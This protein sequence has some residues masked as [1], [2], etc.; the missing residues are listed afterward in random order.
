MNGYLQQLATHFA[1]IDG[2]NFYTYV[3]PNRRAGLFFRKY[4]GQALHKPVLAPEIMTINDCFHSLSD[5][6]IAD[7]LELIARLYRIYV[8]VCSEKNNAESFE[9]FLHWGQLMI[10]DFSEIDNHLVCNVKDLFTTIRDYQQLNHPADYLTKTQVEAIQQFWGD[11]LNQKKENKPTQQFL[12]IWDMLYPCYTQLQA[13]LINDGLAYEGLL[14]RKV[15]ESW[16]SISEEKFQLNT[17]DNKKKH[18]VFIGFN[19]LTAS[20]EKLLLLLQEKGIADFYFDYESPFLHD[21]QNRASLFHTHNAKLFHSQQSIQTFQSFSIPETTLIS[22][23][24]DIGETHQVYRILNQINPQPEDWTR[25]AIV[26]PDENILLP[27]LHAIPEQ[28]EKV[29]VTMG[30]PLQ[31]TK[32]FAPIRQAVTHPQDSTPEEAI[33]RLRHIWENSLNDNNS[34]IIYRLQTILNR[35]EDVLI[36]PKNKKQPIHISTDAF[37]QILYLLASKSS[38]SYIGE[39]LNGL[40]IMGVL[41]TRALDFDNLIITGFNDE[42]YPGK[43]NG[44]SFIPYTLRKGFGLPT[45]ERQDAI[46]A[47]NFYRMFSY[48][49]HVWLITNSQADDQHTGEVSRYVNQLKYQY[50]I[51]I[52]EQTIVLEN[53]QSTIKTTT[54]PPTPESLSPTQPLHTLSPS[55]LVAFLYCKRKYY[56]LYV[57]GLKEDPTNELTDADLGTAVHGVLEEL[58]QPYINQDVT[59]QIIQ[60]ILNRLPA[61][62]G[63]FKALNPIRNDAIMYAVA[64]QLITNQLLMDFHHP[65]HY[66]TSERI[67]KGSIRVLGKDIPLKGKIDRIDRQNNIL[68][69]IDYKT[70]NVTL[71]Y[72]T[73][74]EV[75]QTN[76]YTKVL[77]TLTY[78]YLAYQSGIIDTSLIIQPHLFSLRRFG[79]D[80]NTETLV[81]PSKNENN[82][83]S[84]NEIA[85]QVEQQLTNLLEKILTTSDYERTTEY[86]ACESCAFVSICR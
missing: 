83:F 68:R 80:T 21:P 2:A 78:C 27:L 67:V 25:T 48:A 20:E 36:K 74:D 14:H 42:L 72:S 1:N 53:T 18:F 17:L 29:N 70:G 62:W 58:Y 41:E 44:N 24:S 43:S 15:I 31:A 75:F 64:Q 23:P 60:Q 61:N 56:Y 9:Y 73:I 84:F 10:S 81:Q 13:S 19:A 28:I 45:P 66:L 8:S 71:N 33:L 5:L 77:Q 3:F 4:F 22:V 6:H 52:I 79:T 63:N 26:L 57:L 40:Q 39:P 82:T 76:K 7:D 85:L 38:V 16:N 32:E 50:Q 51:P 30:Y 34:E 65:F 12:R 59:P 86:K 11:V 47:Y 55:A 69:I 46:F 37:Y 54:P 35:I 49:K